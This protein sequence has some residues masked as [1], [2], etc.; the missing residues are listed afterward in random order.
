MQDL[1]FCSSLDRVFLDD[2]EE[3]LFF[4]PQQSKVRNAIV[5]SIRKF[6]KPEIIQSGTRL[7]I[8]TDRFDHIQGL[9]VISN[10]SGR[11]QLAGVGLYVRDHPGNISIVH[12]AVHQDYTASGE[13]AEQMVLIRMINELRRIAAQIKGIDKITLLYNPKQAISISVKKHGAG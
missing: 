7:R 1:V 2:L 9:F 10:S 8:G 12:I 11:A 5:E 6:G 13:H 4:H 3:I